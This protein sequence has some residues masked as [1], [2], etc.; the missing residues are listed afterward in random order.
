MKLE[1]HTSAEPRMGSIPKES[2]DEPGED[3]MNRIADS[4]YEGL[5]LL[6]VPLNSR[7]GQP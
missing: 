4:D 1:A 6:P 3:E 2:V 7:C 5:P